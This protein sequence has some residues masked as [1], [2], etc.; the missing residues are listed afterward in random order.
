LERTVVRPHKD[1]MPDALST[2]TTPSES[3]LKILGSKFYGHILPTGSM[4]AAE[5]ILKEFQLRFADATHVCYALRLGLLGDQYRY[6]DAGEPKNT[7]GLPIYNALRSAGISNVLC[8][9][10]RYYGGTKLGTGG[11]IE[12]YRSAAAEAILQAKLEPIIDKV[13]VEFTC[14]YQALPDLYAFLKKNSLSMHSQDLAERARILV[15][16]ERARL[17][18]IDEADFTY[19][20]INFTLIQ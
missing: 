14:A 19:K 1:Q 8:L 16:L 9:V 11:L 17:S 5:A 7:A 18:L 2:I 10:V 13:M 4:A 20:N 6:S 3:F 12:A 15:W